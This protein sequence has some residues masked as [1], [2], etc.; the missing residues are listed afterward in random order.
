[1]TVTSLRRFLLGSA[2]ALGFA[3]LAASGAQAACSVGVSMFTLGAPYYAAQMAAAVDQAKKAG[4]TVTTADGQNDL[5]KQ[6]GDVEDMVS[7]GVQLAD[8]QPARPRGLGAG[9][10]CR[11]PRRRQG[12]GDRQR[13]RPQGQLS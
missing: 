8:H 4:C 6:I 1:M 7:K 10:Q 2:L 12:G 11:R 9:G 3:P 5:T 13:P